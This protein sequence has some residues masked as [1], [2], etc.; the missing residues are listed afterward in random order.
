MIFTN[1]VPSTGWSVF[2]VAVVKRS[3]RGNDEHDG[4]Q[5]KYNMLHTALR[6]MIREDGPL[7]LANAIRKGKANR[8]YTTEICL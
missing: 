6:L 1:R 4:D 7:K 2:G 5:N 8:H 3:K